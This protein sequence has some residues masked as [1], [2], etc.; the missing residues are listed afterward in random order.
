MILQQ[1]YIGCDIS[2]AHLALFDPQTDRHWRIK[3]DPDTIGK[4]LEGFKGRPVF[5]VFEA[6][7]NYD[8]ALRYGLAERHI[9]SRRLNPFMAKRFSEATGKRAKTDPLDAAMLSRLGQSLS[10]PADP[11]L[12]PELEKLSAFNQLRD[13][14]VHMRTQ[15]K[16]RLKEALYP[17]I[18]SVHQALIVSLTKKIKDV[19]KQIDAFIGAHDKMKKKARLLKSAP[20]IGPVTATTLISSLPELGTVSAK[21][22]ASLAGLAPYNHDSGQRKGRRAIGGGRS[23]V[24]R[25]LYMATLSIVQR[26]S[27]YQDSYKALLKRGKP[28]KLALIAVARKLLIHL[29]AMIRTNQA[30]A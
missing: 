12:C 3:N 25:S 10:P 5:F 28:K 18:T 4:T 13:Q 8:R 19:E 14:L 7:G 1:N 30:W 9:P 6:T 26:Q 22:I 29:N 11:P 16:A 27:V 24:R 23:R 15:E 2:K 20:G 21:T 17:E